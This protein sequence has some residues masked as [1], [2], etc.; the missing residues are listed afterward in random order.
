MHGIQCQVPITLQNLTIRR[1]QP[2]AQGTY[3]IDQS[4]HLTNS[5]ILPTT[6]PLYQQNVM[7]VFNSFLLHLVNH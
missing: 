5:A 3:L 2:I 1:D 7:L 4:P 6:M